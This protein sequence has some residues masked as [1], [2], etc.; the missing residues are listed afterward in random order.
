MLYSKERQKRKRL[1]DKLSFYRQ[2][3]QRLKNSAADSTSS[4][5]SGSLMSS[6][7]TKQPPVGRGMERENTLHQ[8]VILYKD[9][10]ADLGA[11]SMSCYTCLYLR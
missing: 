10:T 4:A 9:Q 6:N 5:F 2:L 3:E 8:E 11:R 7:K 1:G